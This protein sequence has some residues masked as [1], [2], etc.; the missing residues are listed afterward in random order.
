M[1]EDKAVINI[2]QENQITLHIAARINGGLFKTKREKT[3]PQ[4]FKPVETSG[5]KLG[6]LMK[7]YKWSDKWS[8]VTLRF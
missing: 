7:C 8:M 6:P 3:I 4:Q 5:Y 1:A 2:A